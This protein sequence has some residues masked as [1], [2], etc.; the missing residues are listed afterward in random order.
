MVPHGQP[1]TE[2]AVDDWILLQ[3]S[4][5]LRLEAE[6]D[7]VVYVNRTLDDIDQGTFLRFVKIGLDGDMARYAHDIGRY[8]DLMLRKVPLQNASVIVRVKHGALDNSRHVECLLDGCGIIYN[9]THSASE[10]L[11]GWQLRDS[12][13]EALRSGWQASCNTKIAL[14]RAGSTEVLKLSLL[15][16]IPPDFGHPRADQSFFPV[17]SSTHPKKRPSTANDMPNRKKPSAD[18]VSPS[19]A[20]ETRGVKKRPT[21]ASNV[22]EICISAASDIRQRKQ[23]SHAT[24]ETRKLRT[25]PSASSSVPSAATALRWR[26]FFFLDSVTLLNVH[27]SLPFLRQKS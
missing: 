11:R 13:L 24:T 2:A 8:N 14:I 20:T 9:S 26:C 16:W 21:A 12:I 3:K 18:K 7:S 5:E 17:I 6:G 22:T 23:S 1:F 4:G 10:R 15:V 25:R 27:L 19:S